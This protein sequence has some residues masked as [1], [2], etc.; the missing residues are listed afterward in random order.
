MYDV[1]STLHVQER[2]LDVT[3]VKVEVPSLIFALLEGLFSLSLSFSSSF[4]ARRIENEIF[5]ANRPQ[6]AI[7]HSDF[8]KSMDIVNYRKFAL[9]VTWRNSLISHS[10][11]LANT[12]R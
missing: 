8:Q 2:N 4:F 9:D 7:S 1:T 6:C 12:I 3:A 5:A 11:S 10:S